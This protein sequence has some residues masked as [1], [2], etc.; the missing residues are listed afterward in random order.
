MIGKEPIQQ[1]MWSSLELNLYSKAG[2]EIEEFLPSLFKN[3]L[4]SEKLVN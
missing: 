2:T 3:Y 1:A 4:L